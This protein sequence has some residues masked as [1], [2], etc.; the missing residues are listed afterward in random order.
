MVAVQPGSDSGHALVR[1][2]TLEDV[3]ALLLDLVEAVDELTRLRDFGKDLI[4]RDVLRVCR[5]VPDGFW[6][7]IAR[8]IELSRTAG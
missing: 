4:L 7:W 6:N 3:V 1:V 2:S 5:R 8:G